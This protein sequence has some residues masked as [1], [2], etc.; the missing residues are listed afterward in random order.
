MPPFPLGWFI[1]KVW[2]CSCGL[3]VQHLQRTAMLGGCSPQGQRTPWVL[4]RRKDSA[5][6]WP[7]AFFWENESRLAIPCS[8]IPRGRN[9]LF[10]VWLLASRR[11]AKILLVAG[12]THGWGDSA[13]VCAGRGRR[14]G[15][16]VWMS[17][18]HQQPQL[19]EL[20]LQSGVH[21][22]CWGQIAFRLLSW[23]Y[24]FQG[25]KEKGHPEPWAN[26]WKG[27]V[28]LVTQWWL[29]VVI[30]VCESVTQL[31]PCKTINTRNVLVLN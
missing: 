24:C 18:D 14:S 15:T 30:S 20:S 8:A 7:Q 23:W 13:A 28:P 2:S 16:P 12:A 27:A 19:L 17:P 3:D 10:L 4:S 21:L 1:R 11:A 25:S 6:P 31:Y 29:V 5:K 9:P 26:S 22:R